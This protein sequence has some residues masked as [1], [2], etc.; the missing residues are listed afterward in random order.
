MKAI[1]QNP[2]ND[3]IFQVIEILYENDDNTTIFIKILE[4]EIKSE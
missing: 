4:K 3:S 2:F 1:Y